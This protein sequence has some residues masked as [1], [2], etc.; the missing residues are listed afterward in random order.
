MPEP[1]PTKLTSSSAAPACAS[2]KLA[3]KWV[4]DPGAD[5]P[6]RMPLN[7]ATLRKGQVRVD[8]PSANCGARPNTARLRSAPCALVMPGATAARSVCS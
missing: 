8:A 3:R 6:T 1:T 4:D 7:R 2:H 5:T